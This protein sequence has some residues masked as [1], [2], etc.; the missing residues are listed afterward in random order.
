MDLAGPRSERDARLF[1]HLENLYAL[2][3]G[4]DLVRGYQQ[5]RVS[6]A[7]EG[8]VAGKYIELVEAIAKEQGTVVLEVLGRLHP[9]M[10]IA[11]ALTKQYLERSRALATFAD[12]MVDGDTWAEEDWQQF[13]TAN[14]WI[15]GHGLAYQF[16]VNEQAKP[17]MG[18]T[19]PTGKGG[20]Y[21]DFLPPRRASRAS[22]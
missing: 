22:Q 15:F 12:H 11:E 7:D 20:Q 21:G 10:V 18:G 17:Y 1:H 4:I 19:D 3:G 16:L 14:D 2:G 8:V 6:G 5:L 9:E 13:F